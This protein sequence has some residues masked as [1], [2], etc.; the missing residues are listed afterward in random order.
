MP[1]II[2]KGSFHVVGYSPDGDSI[3]FKADNKAHWGKLSGP[4]VELNARQHAQLR[5]EAIDTLETHY[6]GEHQ[7]LELATKALEFLLSGLGITDVQWNESRTK[8]TKAKDGTN[9]YI[10]SR[11]VESNRR[12]VA[13]VFAGTA[14]E[15]D[16]SSVFLDV[17][18]MRQS[19]NFQSLEAGLAYPTYYKGLFYDLRN[20]LSKETKRARKAKRGVWAKDRTNAGFAVPNLA[21]ITNQH[22]I[23]PKLFRRLVKFLQ[24]GG[25]VAGFKNY[26]E[27]QAE[28]VTIISTAHFTHFD[29]VVE[30]NG[31]KVKLTERPE[32]LMFE[33]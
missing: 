7:P 11:S 27:Q 1:F 20:E 5:I 19:L 10:I 4:S 9:G 22:V 31:N 6:E 18:R 17:P 28:G 15:A 25:S 29:T 3:R 33:G 12:P 13:F 30:V 2:I 8:V 21:A 26:L 14:P 24:G 16:G 32:N 23:L